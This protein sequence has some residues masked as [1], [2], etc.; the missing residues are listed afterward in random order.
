MDTTAYIGP[1]D[2]P[3]ADFGNLTGQPRGG[4]GGAFDFQAFI[5]LPVVNVM[6]TLALIGVIGNGIAMYILVVGKAIRKHMP[7]VFLF[8]QSLAD[9]MSCCYVL[10]VNYYTVGI[11][12]GGKSGVVDY[13]F[14]IALRAGYLGVITTLVSTY[15]LAMIAAERTLSILWPVTHRNYVTENSQ[16]R[17]VVIVWVGVASMF[18]PFMLSNNGINP[19]GFCYNWDR[20]SERRW[21]ILFIVA[22]ETASFYAPLAV[23]LCGYAGILYKI[24]SA[25]CT[26]KK[27]AM[28]A[29]R[30]LLIVV[31]VYFMCS[32]VAVDAQSGHGFR[33]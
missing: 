2:G 7:Y 8:N 4:W 25:Q 9:L 30:T 6:T 26:I 17:A 14:C 31:V 5:R 23:I 33:S 15:N 12:Y 16:K 32:V 21:A 20:V 24:F 22:Y 27:R 3:T 28:N 10:S 13:L 11:P 19:A 29:L 18:L 1:Y